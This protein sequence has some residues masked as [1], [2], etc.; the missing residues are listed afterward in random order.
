MSVQSSL[1]DHDLQQTLQNRKRLQGNANL[2]YWYEQLYKDVFG[3]VADLS[4]K[5]ILEIGSG[6]SPLKLFYPQVVT[7][8][9]LKLDYLDHVFDC[10]EIDRYDAIPD[11]SV[12]IMTMTNVLHHVKDPLVFLK[13]AAAKL[14]PGGEVVMIEPYFSALSYPIYKL[15]HHEPADFSIKRPVLDAVQGPLSSSNQAIPYLLFT[16]RPEWLREL[17]PEY[18]ISN[19][20]TA[21][22]SSLSYSASGGI[23]R[24]SFLPAAVYRPLFHIDRLL[25]RWAP[26]LFA[27][28]FI[29]RLR[30]STGRE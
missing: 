18:D 2:L 25:A 20:R 11:R 4:N 8:D 7:S 24:S 12:D 27:S 3:S 14:R 23:S 9:V 30:G 5:S 22:F 17:S 28:F 13:K 21:Y 1:Y 16:S 10:H 6:T 29:V 26:R 19:V 15:I